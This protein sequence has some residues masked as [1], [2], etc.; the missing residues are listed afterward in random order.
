MRR[1]TMIRFL[2]CLVCV[3]SILSGAVPLRATI[4]CPPAQCAAVVPNC[5]AC[6][7]FLPLH[8]EPCVDSAGGTHTYVL[9]ACCTMIQHGVCTL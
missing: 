1:T 4:S 3:A 6:G 5:N 9:F 7:L 8:E 2:L